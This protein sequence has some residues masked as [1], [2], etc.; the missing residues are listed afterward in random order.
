MT[1]RSSCW[2]VPHELLTAARELLVE[3]TARGGRVLVAPHGDADGLGAGAITIEAI[4][5]MGG[6]PIPMLPGKGEHV[7]T[8]AMRRRLSENPAEA[9]VV[10]DMGSRRGPIVPGLPTIVLDHHDAAEAPDGVIFLSAAGHEPVAT[11]GLLAYLLFAPI[12][13]IADLAWL[14]LVATVGDLGADHPF[15]EELGE[16]AA[17]YPKTHV[18]ETV[19]MINAARRA[20]AYQPEVALAVLLAAHEPADIARARVP[21]V[22]RL[23]ACRAEVTA[24]VNR[25]AR[26]PPRIVNDVALIRFSSGAQIHPLIAT[27]WT[28][29]LAPKI[30]LVAN[31]GYLPGRVN[32]AMRSASDVDLLGYLRGLG[33]GTV[34][35]EFANGHPRATG[36]SVPP[37]EFQRL[38]QA[39][40]FPPPR[41]AAREVMSRESGGTAR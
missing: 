30:V 6:V 32:F 20:A 9:L 19:S 7:H 33:L 23:Q 38:L 11:T 31:D 41:R 39:I 35:G 3:V 1:I 8:E 16:V 13:P 15:T 24:E 36:G 34:E 25:V 37:H 2:P 4:R 27:R 22:E 21:G 29:R 40:G 10:L 12:A 26:I 28:G 5:R 18:R 17:R 14:A